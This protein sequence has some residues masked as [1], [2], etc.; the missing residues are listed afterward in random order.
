MQLEN[1]VISNVRDAGVDSGHAALLQ[2][3]SRTDLAI[4]GAV[5]DTRVR[6]TYHLKFKSICR[7]YINTDSP[8]DS[9]KTTGEDQ[10]ER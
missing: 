10:F 9:W 6:L 8:V 3:S 2:L 7:L 5:D 1:A 4:A